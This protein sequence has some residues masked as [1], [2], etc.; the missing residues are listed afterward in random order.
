MTIW[1]GGGHWN[2]SPYRGKGDRKKLGTVATRLEKDKKKIQGGRLR[3]KGYR[4]V[5]A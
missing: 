5:V 2:S 4:M 3:K 1:K